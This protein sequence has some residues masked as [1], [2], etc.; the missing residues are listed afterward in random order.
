VVD[1]ERL[2]EAA[3]DPL[4]AHRKAVGGRSKLPDSVNFSRDRLDRNASKNK[5]K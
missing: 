4:E 1:A 3:A 5:D 2:S